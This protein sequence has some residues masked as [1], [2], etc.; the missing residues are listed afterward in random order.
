MHIHDHK[1]QLRLRIR[2]RLAKMSPRIRAAESRS[3]CRRIL[4]DL[5]DEPLVVCAYAAMPSE[6][7]LKYLLDDLLTDTSCSIF[8]PRFTRAFFEYRHIVTLDDLEP[9]KFNLPEPPA[10]ADLLN[11]QDVTHAFLPGLAFDKQG[12][13]IGRG[14]G[15][16]DRWLQDLRKVNTKAVV[17]GIALECQLV[18]SVPFE[19]HDQLVDAVVTPREIIRVQK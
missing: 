5:P 14:N 3:I 12:H 15:G 6:A 7:D 18:E 1:E 16:F 13:R 9:G 19:A 4:Q 8:L 11:L 10:T 17:W 2:E